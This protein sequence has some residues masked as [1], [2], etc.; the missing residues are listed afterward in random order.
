ML[1]D[2]YSLGFILFLCF[3]QSEVPAE[4]KRKTHQLQLAKQMNE[5]AKV[6]CNEPH[7]GCILHDLPNIAFQP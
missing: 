1:Y 4:D 3:T 7:A 6:L 5:E 2:L